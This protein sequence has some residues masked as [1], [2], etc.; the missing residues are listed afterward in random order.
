MIDIHSHVIFDVDDGPKTLEESLG[1]I[2]EA[3]RQG[4]R[5]IVATSHRR[6]GMFETPEKIIMANYL[7]LKKMVS[8]RLPELTLCYGGELYYTKDII[9][10]LDA[11]KLPTLNGTKQVLVEFSMNTAWKEIQEAVNEIILLG[12]TPVIAHIERYDALAF[13]GE[14]V[15]ELID[16]GCF[17]QVN[18][19]HVLKPGLIGDVAK[20][21]KKRVQYF[22]DNDLVT[23]VASDMHNL[24]KR[25][26]YM[27]EAFTYIEKE[28]GRDRARALFNKNPLMLLK[29]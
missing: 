5:M 28:Y 25:K 23:C 11:K 12:L 18:S 7:E 26:P 19:N 21:F 24:S 9:G 8:E 16:K 17:T 13:K 10:K 22:L 20:P 27:Q 6:K 29:N 15:A 3:R 14:R 4:V 2:E 1:L